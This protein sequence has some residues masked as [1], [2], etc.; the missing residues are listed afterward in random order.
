[1]AA[2][3]FKYLFIP[4]IPIAR[5]HCSRLQPG[6]WA[7]GS[8][9]GA[10]GDALVTGYNTVPSGAWKVTERSAAAWR[11]TEVNWRALSKCGGC[12]SSLA[13]YCSVTM[14]ASIAGSFLGDGGWGRIQKSPFSCE[15][16]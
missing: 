11:G 9:V 4:E 1:M 16:S 2:S 14:W 13:R 7:L 3:L 15:I 6:W 8:S 10:P 12:F 5:L